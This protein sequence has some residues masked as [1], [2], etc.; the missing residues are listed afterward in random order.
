[1][2]TVSVS[3]FHRNRPEMLTALVEHLRLLGI[4][5]NSIA[6]FDDA[7]DKLLKV[8]A[9]MF[10]YR[11]QNGKRG[12]WKLMDAALNWHISTG[13][14]YHVI[15]PD[16]FERPD[17]RR[18]ITLLQSINRPSVLNFIRDD[19]GRCWGDLFQVEQYTDELIHCGYCDCGF[20]I[21]H[22]QLGRL[23][24]FCAPVPDVWFNTPE[25]SSGVGYQLTKRMDARGIKM[26]TPTVSLARHG[27]HDSRMHYDHR[28]DNPIISIH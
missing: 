19:R 27:D 25:K 21:K 7:S 26:F 10:K 6:V 22:E 24:A 4:G 14:D 16:D 15:L 18:A 28:K 1:M 23:G 9:I 5:G 20:I 17:I 12:F 3:I 13:A 8:D 11:K 2:N